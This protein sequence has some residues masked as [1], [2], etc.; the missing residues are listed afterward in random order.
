MQSKIDESA[1]G[2][3]CFYYDRCP[4]KPISLERLTWDPRQ[5]F[6]PSTASREDSALKLCSPADSSST[7]MKG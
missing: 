7:T 2:E 5:R 6:H 3:A 1:E 4:V